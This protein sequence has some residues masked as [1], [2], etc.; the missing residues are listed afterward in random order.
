MRALTV[1]GIPHLS[2]GVSLTSRRNRYRARYQSHKWSL[3]YSEMELWNT[4]RQILICI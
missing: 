2:I 1:I 4:P 3:Y